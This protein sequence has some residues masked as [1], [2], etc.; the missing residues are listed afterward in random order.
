M[1][2]KYLFK[3]LRLNEFMELY[4]PPVIYGTIKD[5][6]DGFIHLSKEC[7]VDDIIHKIFKESSTYESGILLKFNTAKL[8]IMSNNSLI[9]EQTKNGYYYHLYDENINIYSLI[10]IKMFYYNNGKIIK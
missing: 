7:Q 10:N 5:N 6:K 1:S 8:N 3:I 4:K 9:L 2:S